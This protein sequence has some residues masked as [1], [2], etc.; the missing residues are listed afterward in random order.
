MKTSVATTTAL[1]TAVTANRAS[2]YIPNNNKG[3]CGTPIDNEAWAVALPPSSY[4][5][6]AHCGKEIR[7]SYNGKTLNGKVA[8][9]C[10]DCAG[11][12]IDLVKG[13]F[14]QFEKTEKGVIEVDWK[15]N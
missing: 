3:A 5:N 11:A 13:F 1:V 8:D 2:F 14:E 9:L 4:E 7:I 6:G 12:Q 10:P 15:L